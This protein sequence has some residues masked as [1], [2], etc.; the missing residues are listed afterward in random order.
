M[1][2]QDFGFFI[3]LAMT[4]VSFF[5]AGYI[6]GTTVNSRNAQTACQAKVEQTKVETVKAER[7]KA[8]LTVADAF[9]KGS[10]I[11]AWQGLPSGEYNVYRIAPR[12]PRQFVP[13]AILELKSSIGPS[14]GTQYYVVAELPDDALKSGTFTVK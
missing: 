6:S 8:D 12:H 3:G 5:V 10:T 4:I 9:W 1:K 13:A 7:S 2:R 14:K 11:Y